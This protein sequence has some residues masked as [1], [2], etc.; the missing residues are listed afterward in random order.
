[1]YVRRIATAALAL[2]TTA[3]VAFGVSGCSDICNGKVVAAQ[4]L[5]SKTKLTIHK[6]SQTSRKDCTLTDNAA[7][8]IKCKVGSTYPAC[9]N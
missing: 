2:T 6:A 7:T 4:S 3:A 8:L 1:V 5:G 9:A